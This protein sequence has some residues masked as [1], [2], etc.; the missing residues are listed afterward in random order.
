MN[1]NWHP[2]NLPYPFEIETINILKK[3]AI[4][5]RNLAELK[6]IAKSIPHPEILINSLVLQEAK[7]SSEIE[8]IVTTHDELYKSN[9]DKSFQMS[10][11]NKEVQNYVSALKHGFESVKR[12]KI[13]STNH[14]CEIQAIL[15]QNNA[16]LRKQAGTKLRNATTNEVIFEP[17][18][19]PDEIISLMK[20]LEEFINLN[21]LNDLDP[22]VKMAIIH[23]Q[24]ESIHPFYDGNGRTGRILNILYL[25]LNELLD[26]P[27]LYLSKYII[28]N[29]TNYYRFLQNI[30]DNNEWE[31]WIIFFIDCVNETAKKTK[32]LVVQIHESMQVQ[33]Q[34][35]RKEIKFYSQ[36]L[37]NHLF[38]HPYT[39]IDFLA[40]DLN[41][42]RITAT[43]Y[44]NALTKIGF[45][46]KTKF[47]KTYYYTNNELL[48]ILLTA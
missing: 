15:E 13:I 48:K 36:E 45:L 1:K 11:A 14:I 16:G 27:I 21:D 31:E 44:L 23:F 33:K 34:L 37:L 9:M 25:V 35:L 47:G 19:H 4:A 12:W 28:K 30:R 7:D 3:V 29:K 40:S 17:P 39:K 6:G 24:F 2:Q 32:D 41:F 5:H 42:S 20:N 46:S 22:I 38:K 26:L 8:N 43:N 10:A 18:Q